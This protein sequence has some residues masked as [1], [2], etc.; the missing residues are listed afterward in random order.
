MLV[1]P[2]PDVIPPC[3]PLSPLMYRGAMQVTFPCCANVCLI[4]AKLQEG[5]IQLSGLELKNGF[6][7]LDIVALRVHSE[8]SNLHSPVEPQ[9]EPNHHWAHCSGL[10]PVSRYLSVPEKE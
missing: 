4:T 6:H 9:K 5:S 8:A 1:I 10:Y 3:L 7:Q 2:N